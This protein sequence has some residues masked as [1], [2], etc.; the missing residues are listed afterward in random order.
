MTEGDGTAKYVSN[1]LLVKLW[2][3]KPEV[4][5]Y[6]YSFVVKWKNDEHTSSPRINNWFNAVSKFPKW[7]S[8]LKKVSCYIGLRIK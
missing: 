5:K 7:K 6:M 1:V 3:L 4:A 8:N 2:S